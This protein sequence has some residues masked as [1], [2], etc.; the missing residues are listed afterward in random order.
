MRSMLYYTALSFA[1]TVLLCSTIWI[2]MLC[3]I[4]FC[5]GN[6]I[7]GI[8]CSA[9]GGGS[10]KKTIRDIELGETGDSFSDVTRSLA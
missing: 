4:A 1:V 6:L 3:W 5:T 8:E 7:D 2:G 10:S 9:A